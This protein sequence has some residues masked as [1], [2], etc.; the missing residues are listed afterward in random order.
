MTPKAALISHS[1]FGASD[2]LT[3]RKMRRALGMIRDREPGLE[4][5]GEM[6]ADAALMQS[7]RDS[8]V[9]NSRLTASPIC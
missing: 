7:I 1:S 2:S 3:A 8:A 5:D 6:H 4:I 9:P